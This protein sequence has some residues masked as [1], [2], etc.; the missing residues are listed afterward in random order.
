[1]ITVQAIIVNGAFS[2]EIIPSDLTFGSHFDGEVFTYFESQ[3]E[4][5][6]FYNNLN[7]NG[8]EQN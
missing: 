3:E 5:E 8:N 4:K 1:M 7:N 6:E 2:P